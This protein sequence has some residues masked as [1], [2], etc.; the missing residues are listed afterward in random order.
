MQAGG[1]TAVVNASLLGFVEAASPSQVLG[2]MGGPSGL[3]H[4]GF[5][6]LSAAGVGTAA[7]KSLHIDPRSARRPGALLGAGRYPFSDSEL[8]TAGESLREE[9]I[10]G[11][12]L[13]GGNGTMFL[14][15]QLHR[16]ALASGSGL[17]VVGVPKTVDNDLLG[18]DHAPGFPSAARFL[19]EATRDLALD[20]LS[21]SSIEQV[22]I[23][24]TLGR[25]SGWLAVATVLARR[26]TGGAPHL[27]YVPERPFDE[28]EFLDRVQRTV[29]E[30]GQAFV[31]VAEGV[32]GPRGPGLFDR[33][34]YDKPMTGGVAQSLAESVRTNFG[35]GVRAEVLGLVQRC[36]SWAVTRADRREARDL[37]A[38]AARL[39]RRQMSGVMVALPDRRSAESASM[40]TAPLELVAGKTR[41]VPDRWIPD[42]ATEVDAGLVDWLGPLVGI[43]PRG[44]RKAK[45]D[46]RP[47]GIGKE[48]TI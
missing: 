14:A 22:R 18:T 39:L 45:N 9:G 5:R 17:A 10:D 43:A 20:H 47:H 12:A 21:M 37:G 13:I 41:S 8:D 2:V 40:V 48:Q 28:K 6:P 44:D 25:A 11:I 35:Y 31:V 23:V 19:V 24:E 4:R 36:A 26:A 15:D 30:R 34:V 16:R 1:P 42:G 7:E 33:V 27:V 32:A 46:D 3:L 38:E 29:C